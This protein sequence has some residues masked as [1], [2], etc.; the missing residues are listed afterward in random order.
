M[1]TK[2][3]EELKQLAIQIRD[4]KTN[5]QNTATRIG[6]QMLEHLN[7]LEQD[8]YD[9][10]ATDEELKQRDEKLTELSSNQKANSSFSNFPLTTIYYGGK[11]QNIVNYRSS[12][13][14]KVDAGDKFVVD[15]DCVSAESVLFYNE[16]DD[17]DF[18]KAYSD[19]EPNNFTYISGLASPQNGVVEVPEGV[20]FVRFQ[21]IIGVDPRNDNTGFIRLKSGQAFYM[22]EKNPIIKGMKK[23]VLPV[24]TIRIGKINIS[25][26]LFFGDSIVAG[27]IPSEGNVTDYKGESIRWTTHLCR[28]LGVS[29]VN[30]AIPG[31]ELT[32]ERFYN[33][34]NDTDE[35]DVDLII[36]G[37][38]INDCTRATVP[39]GDIDD[40]ADAN[41]VHGIFKKIVNLM[42]TK[43]EDARIVFIG[44][45]DAAQEYQVKFTVD[46]FNHAIYQECVINKIGYIKKDDLDFPLETETNIYK[47][48]LPDEL[49]PSGLA[50]EI[51]ANAI[52]HYLS[53]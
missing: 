44:V 7:K 31:Y 27:S 2:T 42:K 53:M 38:G 13:F 26:I 45:Y 51:Y 46:K 3:F 30:K 15:L 8:Y 49:H 48:Y 1:A 12:A 52:Y 33:Q 4:E 19:Q 32:T 17:A 14:I 11:E 50:S 18:S 9:K 6:T 20:S 40:R 34:I 23:L 21:S 25:K 41:T 36:V 39:L 5:K 22:S 10:T 16:S 37:I 24:H 47:T 28:M 29:E 43:W 35:Q